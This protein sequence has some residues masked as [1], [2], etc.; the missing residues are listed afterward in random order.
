M[1]TAVNFNM[2]H[3][4]RNL[5]LNKYKKYLETLSF[6]LFPKNNWRSKNLENLSVELTMEIWMRG[7]VSFV[8]GSLVSALRM[9]EAGGRRAP[10][11]FFGAWESQGTR[12]R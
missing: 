2:R 8:F 7:I 3:M 10:A 11:E 6:T 9:G 1:K 4:K 12:C 5:S